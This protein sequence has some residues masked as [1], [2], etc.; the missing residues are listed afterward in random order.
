MRTVTEGERDQQILSLTRTVYALATEVINKRG[1]PN[2]THA[3]LVSAGWIGAMIAVDRY[4]PEHSN[5]ANLQTFARDRIYG[6]M[7]DEVRRLTGVR[8]AQRQPSDPEFQCAI[9]QRAL[10]PTGAHCEDLGYEDHPVVATPWHPPYNRTRLD[11]VS[12]SLLPQ[13]PPAPKAADELSRIET[14]D[15]L[16]RCLPTLKPRQREALVEHFLNEQPLVVIAERWG[17]TESRVSQVMRT[18]LNDARAAI[19]RQYA[20]LAEAA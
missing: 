10:S 9:C 18:G 16:R 11:T 3:E 13:D 14:M 1:R 15:V 6:E 7:L 4:D 20:G 17:V 8:R 19:E 5:G 2:P 12:I